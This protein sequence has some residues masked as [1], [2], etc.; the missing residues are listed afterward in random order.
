MPYDHNS[1]YSDIRNCV[2]LLRRYD[3]AADSNDVVPRRTRGGVTFVEVPSLGQTNQLADGFASLDEYAHIIQTRG[4]VAMLQDGA[5][6]QMSYTFQGEL[7]LRHSLC[8]YPCP[9]DVSLPGLD[10]TPAAYLVGLCSDPSEI[11][12]LRSPLRFD[13][14]LESQSDD[15]PGSHLHVCLDRCRCAVSTPLSVG[16]FVRFVF[17]N[18]YRELWAAHGFLREFKAQPMVTTL[19]PSQRQHFHLCCPS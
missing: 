11:P 2:D 3:I 12:R 19:L 18:F 10:D 6:L 15:H 16:H 9:Y 5:L 14:D 7:L 17:Y 1:A 8:Y 4:F 13:Y